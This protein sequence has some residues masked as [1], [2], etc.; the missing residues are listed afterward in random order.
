MFQHHDRIVTSSD[1]GL[2]VRC[3]Y[4]MSNRTVSNAGRLA[5]GQGLKNQ[6]G[7]ENTVVKS[8]NVTL[9][10]TNR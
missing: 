7:A 1:V 6:V 9:R 4:N 2:K 3:N 10:V 5:V 8:P